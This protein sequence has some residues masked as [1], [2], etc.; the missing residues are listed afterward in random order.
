[1]GFEAQNALINRGWRNL[2]KSYDEGKMIQDLSKVR[3]FGIKT[4]IGNRDSL[5]GHFN[6]MVLGKWFR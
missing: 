4:G 2:F 1:L 6:A 5:I 3:N